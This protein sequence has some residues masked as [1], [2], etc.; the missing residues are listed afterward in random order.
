M[1]TRQMLSSSWDTETTQKSGKEEFCEELH[2]Q[3]NLKKDVN[4]GKN[5]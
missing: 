4:W 5:F 3:R 2:S 1:S